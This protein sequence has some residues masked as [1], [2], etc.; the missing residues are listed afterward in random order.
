MDNSEPVKERKHSAKYALWKSLGGRTGKP[1]NGSD[2][3]YL[4]PETGINTLNMS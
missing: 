1:S 3:G 4:N 2:I